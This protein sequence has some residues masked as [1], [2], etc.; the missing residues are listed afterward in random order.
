MQAHN[1]DLT[2]WRSAGGFRS[3][4][5]AK[6]DEVDSDNFFSN[7]GRSLRE[8]WVG[9]E[10]SKYLPQISAMRL[11]RD[12]WPDCEAIVG[13]KLLPIEVTE[14]LMPNRARR[15]EYQS[16]QSSHSV[17][18]VDQSEFDSRRREIPIRLRAVC[19]KKASK[20]YPT[21]GA[22]VVYL[23]IGT[24]DWWREEIEKQ[25]SECTQIACD[26]FV[27]VWVIWSGRLYQPW[28]LLHSA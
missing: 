15:R 10:L 25:I 8:A 27:F 1:P 16:A 19:A 17:L 23:N 9:A 11:G 20:C 3:A 22:L 21:N 26:R 24:H 6:L 18:H 14:A 7:D 12:Q 4:V 13:G 2:V 5:K 28:P